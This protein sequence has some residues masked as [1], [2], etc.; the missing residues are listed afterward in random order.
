MQWNLTYLYPTLEAWEEGYKK[1]INIIEKLATYKGKLNEFDT[2]KEYFL[3]VKKYPY[4]FEL[5][6]SSEELRYFIS[7]SVFIIP[8]F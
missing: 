3:N 5:E 1:T 7:S 8:F 4:C 2:F 6:S